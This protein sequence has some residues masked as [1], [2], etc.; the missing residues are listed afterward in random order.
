[1]FERFWEK[2]DKKKNFVCFFE[3][4]LV[5]SC[6]DFFLLKLIKKIIGNILQESAALLLQE[7]DKE[8]R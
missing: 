5:Y 3:I 2:K 4:T 8:L 1:M 6:T 7:R